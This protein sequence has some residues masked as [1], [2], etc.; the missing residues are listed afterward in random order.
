MVEEDSVIVAAIV[1]DTMVV[2]EK[3]IAVAEEG[4]TSMG[5]SI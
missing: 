4:T 5:A 1:E 3:E 2:N